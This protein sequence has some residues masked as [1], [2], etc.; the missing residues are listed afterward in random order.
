MYSLSLPLKY[1]AVIC[2]GPLNVKLDLKD[3]VRGEEQKEKL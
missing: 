1:S 2:N 3:S